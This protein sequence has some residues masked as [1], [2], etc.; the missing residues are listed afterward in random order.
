M[1][2]H[3]L[4]SA[5][6]IK[7]ARKPKLVGLISYQRLRRAHYLLFDIPCHNIPKKNYN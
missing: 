7:E 4:Q 5:H 6:L 1:G 3:F 2:L